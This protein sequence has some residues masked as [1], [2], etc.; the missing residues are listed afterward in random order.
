M[1]KLTLKNNTFRLGSI[2]GHCR[3]TPLAACTADWNN[4]KDK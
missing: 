2:D 3:P 4:K 1:K